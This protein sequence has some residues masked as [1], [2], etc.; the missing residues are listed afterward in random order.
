M[1]LVEE[2]LPDFEGFSVQYDPTKN[3]FFKAIMVD[4]LRKLQTVSVGKTLLK[5]IAEAY[6]RSCGDFLPSVNVRCV[7]TQINYTQSGFKRSVNWGDGGSFTVTG[8]S[9]TDDPKFA[10][11]GCPFHIAG[12]SA[13]AALNAMASTNKT[14]S[15]CT[16]KFSNAQLVTGKGERADPYIVLAHELIH[17]LHCLK[18]VKDESGNE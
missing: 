13:N 4:N 6:P 9:A 12:S 16:M 10:L 15:V 11:K 5:E 17:S 3:P 18:G 8:M 1:A 14:G 7:P 2:L